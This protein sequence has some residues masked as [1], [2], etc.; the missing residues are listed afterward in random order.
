MNELVAKADLVALDAQAVRASV[1]VAAQVRPTDLSRPTP[2]LGWTVYGLLA[3]MATQHYGFAAASGGDG[4]LARWKL[5]SLGD[6]PVASYRVA[7]EHVMAAF[8]VDG[9]LERM[10]PLPEVRSG[11]VFPGTQAISFHFIDYVVHSWDLAKA[12]GTEVVFPP[13]LLDVAL[14][15]AEAVPGGKAREE[16]GA[17]FAPPRTSSGGSRLDE[18]VA[19][20]GR[21]P[22]W[23]E[24][25]RRSTI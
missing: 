7:A 1:E 9:V 4:D 18:I 5:R 13:D 17:A 19:I 12:L 23:P 14:A 6:D 15:V 24:S 2:C 3:H 10:F 21:S 22:S 8:A 16:P 20:L 25:S 11:S